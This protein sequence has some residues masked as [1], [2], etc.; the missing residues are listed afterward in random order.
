MGLECLANAQRS[1]RNAAF[2][3]PPPIDSDGK[4]RVIGEEIFFDPKHGKFLKQIGFDINDPSNIIPDDA[5]FDRRVK[6]SLAKQDVRRRQIEADLLRGHGH[7]AIR[8]FFVLSEPVYNGALGPWLIRFMKLLPYDD[9][10][11]VYLPLD[12]ATQ[13]AMGGAPL[14]PCQN[15]RPIDDLMC[16]QIGGFHSQWMGAKQKVDQHVLKAGP[17]VAKD[18]LAA[19]LEY[20]DAT[21][22]R[23][24]DYVAQVKPMI[25]TLIADVQNKAAKA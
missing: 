25:I 22:Q 2:S 10:N 23:I 13:A 11:V 6:E 16:K 18:V 7:N 21:P 24:L 4:R 14:H 12:R 9:W 3:P 19:F 20:S 1:P 5:E 17:I 8:P 15:I